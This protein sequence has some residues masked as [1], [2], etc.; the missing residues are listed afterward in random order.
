MNDIARRKLAL[1]HI[2]YEY[3]SAMERDGIAGYPKALQELDKMAEKLYPIDGERE[4]DIGGY[5][6]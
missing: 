6:E 4:P 1:A 3:Q 2:E 5:G